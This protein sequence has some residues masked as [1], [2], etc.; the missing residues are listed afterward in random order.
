MAL[1]RFEDFPWRGSILFRGRL[2]R[3]DEI[4]WD[5]LPVY[6]LVQMPEIVLLSLLLSG[7][8]AAYRVA[9]G[10]TAVSSK[11]GLSVALLAVAV[12]FPLIYAIVR[13]ATLYDAAT[14]PPGNLEQIGAAIIRLL[15]LSLRLRAS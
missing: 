14:R 7:G 15:T 11:A 10:K 4:P 12:A 2:V 9:A 1:K 8:W 3:A 6:L 13:S 5:Y